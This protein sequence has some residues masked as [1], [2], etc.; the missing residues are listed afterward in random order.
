VLFLGV[1]TVWQALQ[2]R[3]AFDTVATSMSSAVDRLSEG[4]T[5][6]AAAAL[7][8]GRSAARKAHAYTR[9]PVWWTASK[10]PSVGDDITA[11]RVI[12]EEARTLTADTLPDLVAG[13][14]RFGPDALRPRDGRIDLAPIKEVAPVLERGAQQIGVSADRVDALDTDELNQLLA[15]PVRD[16]Q[17]KLGQARAVS[18]HVADAA[19]LL[20]TMLGEG[21]G[22]GEERTYLV[23][24]QNNAEIRAQGGMP[25]A[26]SLITARDGRI[27]MPF[28]GRPRDIG[29]FRE[30]FVRITGEER[31]LFTPRIA[32][33]P[34]DTVFVPDFARSSEIL[35]QMWEE[36]HP[37]RVDGL[38]S[39]DPT[40]MGY[41]LRGIGPVT[42]DNG[43]RLTADNAADYLMGEVYLE[44]PDNEAQNAIYD[45]T[46]RKV[47]DALRSGRGDARAVLAGLAQAAGERR[48]M[49]WSAD[50]DEQDRIA[51]TPI[52]GEL[53]T[54]ASRTPEVGVY[55]ND[56]AA[57]KLS[58]YLDYRVDVLGASCGDQGNQVLDVTVTMR[59]TVPEGELTPS[60]VGPGI[61]GQPPGVMRNSVYLYAPVEG[62]VD[63]AT[64]DGQ[65]VPTQTLTY[66]GRQVNAVT[67][68]LQRGQKRVLEYTVRTGPGQTGVPRLITTPAARTTGQGTVAGA[69]CS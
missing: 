11:I 10:L 46:S 59:S 19:E 40:A 37:E 67:L 44:V 39:I 32:V 18:A 21:R 63:S 60:V 8:D 47:F 31:Q 23:I 53:P 54:L 14:E 30:P 13:T 25:G 42:L 15:G 58:Y 26:I 4:K 51:R 16:L 57:D 2:V 45:E 38:V 6:R 49:L 35:K 69:D 36:V 41:L 27:E 5:K 20:P 24:F 1:F 43:T 28:Q 65:D 56:S 66:R 12:A 34:Q 61:A 48:L 33:F 55:L 22:K 64:L 7:D 17:D 9:G 52:A 29:S 3:T 68:D 50:G 62:R